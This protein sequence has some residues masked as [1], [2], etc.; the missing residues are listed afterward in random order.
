M[1]ASDRCPVRNP[2]TAVLLRAIAGQAAGPLQNR[3]PR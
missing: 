2:F 1:R 3:A